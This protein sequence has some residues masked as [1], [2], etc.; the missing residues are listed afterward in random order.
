MRIINYLVNQ[1]ILVTC[2]SKPFS[3]D[4][5]HSRRPETHNTATMKRRLSILFILIA[6]TVITALA[7]TSPV[8][9]RLRNAVLGNGAVDIDY[10]YN[11]RGWT[12]NVTSNVFSQQIHY[13]NVSS[14]SEPCFNGNISAIVW[15][16][17][18]T[19][20]A[21]KK[22]GAYNYAYDSLDRLIAANYTGPHNSCFSGQYDY[23]L[24]GNAT[25]IRRNGITDKLLTAEN[26]EICAYGL[27]DDVT[28]SYYGNRLVC[29]DDAADALVYEG[30]MD[31]HD[32]ANEE[33]EYDYDANGNLT[34]D[35]NKGISR[36]TYD[37][38]NL[39]RE[40]R[41]RTRKA[42]RYTY[43]ASGRKLSAEYLFPRN[44]KL[45][46]Y[47]AEAEPNTRVLDKYRV[48]TINYSGDNIY[49]YG[50]LLRT[51]LPTGYIEDDV[52]YYYVKDYQGN[53]R[54][55]VRE[56]GAVVESN[57]YYPYGGLFSATPS[58]QP[59]KYGSKEL[60]RTHGLDWYDS[61]A[62]FYDSVLLRTNS[63]DKKAGDYTW[64]SPYLWCAANPIRFTDPTGKFLESAW[65]IANLVMDGKSL[66]DNAKKGNVGAAI[67]D[68]VGLA[69]DLTAVIVPVMPGGAGSA[70]KAYRGVDK[71]V[72]IGKAIAHGNSKLST[73][74]QHLYE[75][76]KTESGTIVKTGISGGKIAKN[77]KSYRA[78]RQVNK[79][80]KAE[81]E[82]KYDSRIVQQFPAGK[83]AREE[84]LTAE[85]LN[86]D[87][88]RDD[89]TKNNND[90]H[91][92]P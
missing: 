34:K 1:I 31:F 78:T 58:A 17:S 43:D 84:A 40:V 25:R 15:N 13:H 32:G 9:G 33:E 82:G 90:K 52:V 53:V 55:V 67:V 79:W 63:M 50:K 7:H 18:A 91:K 51:L 48:I 3:D 12:T 26:E 20:N 71:A 68:G 41:F 30:A 69:Y 80:N 46:D 23:D 16:Q 44:P 39:P 29:A 75:V 81:G 89:L 8:L 38:N 85:K 22:R 11:L 65:D 45:K 72:D 60:D 27:I 21:N 57:E 35:L 10:E 6:A 14:E 61:K 49:S 66:W 59:Y 73:K 2:G 28:L 88:H 4:L 47:S 19:G 62:R 87:K 70:I 5:A 24:H 76:F 83:G 74:A 56:D 37:W 86:A 36:I 64:L 54:S 42:C 92:R 77:G